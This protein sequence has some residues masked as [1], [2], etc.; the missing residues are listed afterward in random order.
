MVRIIRVDLLFLVVVHMPHQLS[1][2]VTLFQGTPQ[3]VP[4]EESYRSEL[5]R[6]FPWSIN[7][8]LEANNNG[9][10]QFP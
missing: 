3:M 7:Q 8:R 4:I 6:L 2:G 10:S 5:S 9:R 1:T